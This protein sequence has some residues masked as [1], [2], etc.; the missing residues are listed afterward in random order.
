MI[1]VL[2]I[3]VTDHSRHGSPSKSWA[4][5]ERRG[6]R[7]DATRRASCLRR[8]GLGASAGVLGSVTPQRATAGARFQLGRRRRNTGPAHFDMARAVPVLFQ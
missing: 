3:V 2:D 7:A 5:H 1:L 4:G 6:R 8:K